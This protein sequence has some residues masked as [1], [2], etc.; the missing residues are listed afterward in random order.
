MMG[1]QQQTIA[2]ADTT[3]R[4]TIVALTMAVVIALMMALTASPAFAAGGLA[5]GQNDTNYGRTQ[6]NETGDVRNEAASGHCNP[7]SN[8]TANSPNGRGCGN[9]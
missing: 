4:R 6:N 2:A 3:L 1:Q 5:K 8:N 9:N 7:Y